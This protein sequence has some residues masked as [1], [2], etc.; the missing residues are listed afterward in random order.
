V[1][2]RCI[3]RCIRWPI[4]ACS[5]STTYFVNFMLALQGTTCVELPCAPR[6][7]HTRLIN[8]IV[9]EGNRPDPEGRPQPLRAPPA[10]HARGG[11]DTA[12]IERL[13]AALAQGPR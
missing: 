4:C 3:S 12:P 11:A 1:A 5:W 9:L 8:D 13:L 2:P 10:L 6:Q 7:P